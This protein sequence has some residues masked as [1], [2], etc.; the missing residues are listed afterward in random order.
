MSHGQVYGRT[1]SDRVET[2]EGKSKE[3]GGKDREGDNDDNN[4]K[5]F[6]GIHIG[7]INIISGRK[8]RL[9]MICQILE[10]HKIDIGILT[11]T[12]LNGFHTHSAFGY[13]VL[14]S[15]CVNTNQGGVAFVVRKNKN[16]HVEGFK[17]YGQNVIKTTLVHDRQQTTI[18]GI[19]IP[20]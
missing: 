13:R 1:G 19:Y 10:Q 11:E 4:N 17:T 16:W 2:V 14:A 18:V 9:E 15:R 5:K 3:N 8:S 6:N 12:K 7:T 20:P